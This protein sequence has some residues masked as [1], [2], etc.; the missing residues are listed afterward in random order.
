LRLV[1]TGLI[2]G[3]NASQIGASAIL[4][5]PEYG[6]FQAGYNGFSGFR[7]EFKGYS[8]GAG[9]K[10]SQELSVGMVYEKGTNVSSL[11][12]PTYE[13]TIAYSFVSRKQKQ[14]GYNSKR[15]VRKVKASTIEKKA[16]V[17]SD[18]KA[19]KTDSTQVK[20]AT[21][22]NTIDKFKTS[23]NTKFEKTRTLELRPVD[24]VADGFYLVVNV[25]AEKQNLN[26]FLISLAKKKFQPKYF[27]DSSRK[28]YYV[29]LKK[30]ESEDKAEEARISKYEGRYTDDSWVLGVINERQ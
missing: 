15:N 10:V 11:L 27:Y 6:W 22:A 18:E 8:V 19:V 13:I 23:K 20:L 16:P 9:F 26:R 7:N 14:R 28:F 25:F 3:S 29:Y 24:G 21:E 17:N 5:L 2:E 1:A 4:D 30:Y 12:G